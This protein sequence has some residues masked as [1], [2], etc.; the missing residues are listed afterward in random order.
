M[1]GYDHYMEA[2]SIA[3]CL[4]EE[5]FGE[6]ATMVRDAIDY[7]STGTEIFMQLRFY[8]T[9]LRANTQVDETTRSRICVLVNKIEEALT[10]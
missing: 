1:N 8:L 2:K 3:D 6:Q 10:R 7:G 5:G 4:W 9:P